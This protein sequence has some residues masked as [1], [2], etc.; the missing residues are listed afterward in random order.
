MALVGSGCLP[1]QNLVWLSSIAVVV[2]IYISHHCMSY[3]RKKAWAIAEGMAK[4]KS[5]DRRAVVKLE[6]AE[7]TPEPPSEVSEDDECIVAEWVK[8]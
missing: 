6:P 7:P 4:A 8:A 5:V 3:V 1:V 2:G